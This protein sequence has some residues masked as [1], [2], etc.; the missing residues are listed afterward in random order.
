MTTLATS[1]EKFPDKPAI[2]YGDGEF[3]ETYG[4]LEQ[5]SRR[6]AHALRAAG[7]Q[8]GDAIA[9]LISNDNDFFDIFWAAHRLGLYFTPVNWHLQED[10]VHYIVD[11]CD[12]KVLFA[13]AQF[14]EIATRVA[15]R[16]P[17]LSKKISTEG[18]IEGY[19]FSDVMSGSPAEKAGL[20]GGDVLIRYHGK[21]VKSLEEGVAN[22]R[23]G[24][25]LQDAGLEEALESTH[26]AQAANCGRAHEVE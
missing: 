19:Q 12:A 8:P 21:S 16:L 10:E 13:N 22:A 1:A 5:R 2:I 26:G 9:G 23:L 18:E 3:T 20:K 14:S 15:A 4:E 25:Q 24:Q 11:N 7:V 17:Q 6:I